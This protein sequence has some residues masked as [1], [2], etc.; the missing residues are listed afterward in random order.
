[1]CRERDF[2]FIDHSDYIQPDIHLEDDNLHLN[3]YGTI[4]F[5]KK[6]TSFISDL[7]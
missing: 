2:P 4:L 6:L 5:A 1:M 7:Y 3:K